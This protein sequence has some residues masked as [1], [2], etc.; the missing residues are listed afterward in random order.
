MSAF[1]SP[2]RQIT[3]M[4]SNTTLRRLWQQLGIATNWPV[5]AAVAVLVSIGI[6]SI[7]AD[8]RNDPLRQ[9][10]HVKQLVF[11]GVGI[12][13]MVSFQAISYLKIGRWA[14]GFYVLSLLL[15][16]YTVMPGVPQ[17]G[18]G[19]VPVRNGA[20]AWIDFKFMAF[21]PAEVTKI[22]F[23]MVLARYLR[24]RSNYRTVG[25]LMP[26][27]MLALVPLALIMK[28]PDLGTALVFIPVLFAMLFV[29]GAKKWHL[30]AI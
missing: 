29:A 26:P 16:L 30:A 18:F 8:S 9:N 3:A 14:W 13:A 19:S 7:W 12:V 23:V 1:L 17:R 11:L 20:H 24:F 4:S 28:Q 6:V 10:D 22:S 21:Q 27:F 5:L 2:S 25:G 15:L